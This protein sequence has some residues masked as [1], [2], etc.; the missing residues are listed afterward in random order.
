[1]QHVYQL[2]VLDNTCTFSTCPTNELMS[3]LVSIHFTS[4]VNSDFLHYI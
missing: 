2:S 3:H 4:D 1:M